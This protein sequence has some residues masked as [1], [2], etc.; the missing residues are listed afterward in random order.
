MNLQNFDGKLF[1]KKTFVTTFC[2][3]NSEIQ[4]FWIH[5]DVFYKYANFVTMNCNQ[6]LK[7]ERIG[8]SPEILSISLICT[9]NSLWDKL[10]L[11]HKLSK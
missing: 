8:F 10:Q 2:N 6:M 1:K 5:R 7:L 9:G 4:F 3:K 11:I